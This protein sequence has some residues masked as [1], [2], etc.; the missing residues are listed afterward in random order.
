MDDVAFRFFGTERLDWYDGR[1]V[2]WHITDC[3]CENALVYDTFLGNS[4]FYESG[5]HNSDFRYSEFDGSAFHKVSL[6]NCTLTDCDLDG[7]TID[8]VDVK[9]AIDLF[10][11]TKKMSANEKV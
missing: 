4:K 9:E 6:K 1:M 10:K 11:R 5:F 8:G 3:N 7:M 2:G